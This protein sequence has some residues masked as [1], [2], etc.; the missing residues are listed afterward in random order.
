MAYKKKYTAEDRAKKE[1]QYERTVA[2]LF[3]KGMEENKLPWQKPWSPTRNVLDHNYFTME[4]NGTQTNNYNGINSILCELVRT[5]NYN[6]DDPRWCTMAQIIKHNEGIEDPSKK[7]WVKKGSTGTPIKYYTKKYFDSDGKEIETKDG[8]TPKN[9]AYTK[10]I[11]QTY[12]LFHASQ[13]VTYKHNEKGER[14]KDKDGNFIS[15]PAFIYEPPKELQNLD[16][17]KEVDTIIKNTG[18]VIVHD[19]ADLCAYIPTQDKIH[20]VKPEKFKKPEEYYDTLLH[21]LTHWTGHP[22]RLNREEARRYRES[23]EWRAKEELI[24]EIGGYL[25]A[26]ECNIAFT[27]SSNNLAYVNSWIKV[28]Q[29]NPKEI[30]EATK[31]AEKATKYVVEFTR[32]KEKKISLEQTAMLSSP[33]TDKKPSHNWEK[34]IFDN[35]LKNN[36]AHVSKN[37]NKTREK[38][39]F[40]YSR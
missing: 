40:F 28:L 36:P 11:L 27:P 10:S 24:A 37:I 34:D 6:S 4:K 2:D 38:D 25:L 19:T 8:E 15:E 14:L 35:N 23:D 3:I 30:F 20:M 39:D 13:I 5:V 26:R 21:E 29:D 9:P 7:L 32:E 22:D 33:N 18:A 12:N 1:Q 16:F 31:K 17:S